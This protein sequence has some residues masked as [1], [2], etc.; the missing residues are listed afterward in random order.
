MTLDELNIIQNYKTE[1]TFNRKLKNLYKTCQNKNLCVPVLTQL[2]GNCLFESLVYFG[3]GPNIKLLRKY[4]SLLLFTYKNYKNFFPENEYTL[5]EIFRLSNEVEYVKGLDGNYY[6]YTYDTMCQDVMNNYSWT[7]LPT[8]LILM[9]I[10][11]VFKLEIIIL[12]NVGDY[13]NNINI[14]NS[15]GNVKRHTIYLGHIQEAHYFPLIYNVNNNELLYYNEFT[16]L[17]QRWIDYIQQEK[18]NDLY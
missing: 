11:Y 12:N 4:V 9:M 18:Y 7:K 10:S 15:N 3:I 17:L 5:E 16:N 13:E 6:S 8:Q 1:K 14:V 2:D